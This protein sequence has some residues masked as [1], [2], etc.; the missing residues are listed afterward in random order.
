MLLAARYVWPT[1]GASSLLLL[2]VLVQVPC[3]TSL[4]D[5]D[6]VMLLD[7]DPRDAVRSGVQ[8]SRN[9]SQYY[10]QPQAIQLPNG[11]WLLA[12]TNA[13]YAEGDPRQRV[14]S[15]LHPSP[16]LSAGGWLPPVEIEGPGVGDRGSAGWV[17]PLLVPELRRVYAFYTYN[18]DNITTVP[19]HNTTVRV[20]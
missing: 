19:P 1:G 2:L 4:S 16:N 7:V 20:I 12:L 18:A 6:G 15:M 5:G 9:R 8:I 14:V 3:I 10:N 17:V 11:S 13:P